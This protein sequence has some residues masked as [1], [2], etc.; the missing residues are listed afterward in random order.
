[1]CEVVIPNSQTNNMTTPATATTNGTIK[2][3]LVSKEML[4]SPRSD[5]DWGI[6]ETGD[7]RV[8]PKQRKI[9]TPPELQ[10]EIVHI[11]QMNDEAVLAELELHARDMA[12][13]KSLQDK[14]E[15]LCA[16]NSSLD[17]I[18]SKQIKMASL[19]G[20]PQ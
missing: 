14:V 2:P 4:A 7:V 18:N 1:M 10:E 6:S 17:S 9:Q 20:I 13:W 16:I 8:G 11:L 12:H 3:S 19:L 5:E 15:A